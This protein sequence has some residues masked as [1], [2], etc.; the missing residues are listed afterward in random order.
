MRGFSATRLRGRAWLGARRLSAVLVLTIGLAACISDATTPTASTVKDEAARSAGETPRGAFGAFVEG[1]WPEAKARGVSRRTFDAAFAGV[2]PDPKVMELTRKQAE[3]VRPV[4]D[5]LAKAVADERLAKG[6]SMSTQWA[7][8][9]ATLEQRYGVDRSVILGVWG[10]ETNFGST[11][12]NNNVIRALATLAYHRY[13]GDYFRAELMNALRILEE[14]HV[15]PQN[16]MGSWAGAMGHTQFMP[17]SFHRFA[18][19]HDGDSRRD[20]WSVQDALASTANYLKKN[21][22]RTGLPWGFEVTP[23]A[24]FAYG[25]ERRSFA[26]WADAG[27]RRSD[28][29]PMPSG[30]ASLFQPAGARGPAFLVTHNFTVI[31]RYN[32][33]NSYALGVAHLGDRIY[34]GAPIRAS[35][36]VAEAPLSRSEQEAQTRLAGL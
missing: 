4:W 7:A 5:Y 34:G 12:G 27:V 6:R 13:R 26:A 30:E 18:V 1:L 14:G 17:S 21:G 32:N 9:L 8:T 25:A 22:W 10:M 16:M 35:W 15:A 19:D 20:I 3:F 36:P 29:K 28:G 31:K 2:T 11:F 23:P 24:N 33:S